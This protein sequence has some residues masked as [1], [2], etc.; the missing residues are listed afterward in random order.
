MEKKDTLSSCSESEEQQMQL[1]QDKSKESCMVSF[2]RLHSHLKRLS[3]NDL[4]GSRTENGFGRAFATLFGQDFEIFTGTMFLNM[5]QLQKQLDNNE[6]Q[7]IGSMASFK[8]LETQFQMFINS[9]IYLNDEYIV[10]TRN[11]FLQYTQ[12]DIPEFRETLVQFM[13]YVKKSIDERALHKMEYDSRLS[14][15]AIGQETQEQDT[16]S[17]SG[18]DAHVDDAD[19]RPIDN[20]EPMAE[21]QT[22]ADDNVSATRQQHTEQP[23]SNMKGEIQKKGFAIAALKN[24]L[25]KLTGNSVNTKFAKPSI[26]GKPVL[27]PHRNQSVVRQPTAF[28]SERPK[29]S[30]PRFASQVDVNNDLSKPVTTHYLPKRRESAHAKPHYMIAPSSS[31]YSSNDIVHNHYLEEAKKKTQ[32]HSRNSRNFS[33]SKH[34]VC[35]TCQKCV[36]NANHDSCVTKFLKE[37]NSRAK[38]PSNKT[39]NRNK[40]VEQI[41]VA[42]KPNRQIPTGHRFSIKR[43]STVHE[44]TTSPRS[45]LRWQPTGRILKT[46]CLRWVPTG[47][48]FTSSTTKV[49]SEPPNGSKEDITNQCESE[50]ALDVSAD[51][52]ENRA[53]RNFDLMINIMTFEHS[54]SSLGHQCQMMSDHNSS[55]LA[56]QRQ[57]MSV[58]NVTSGLVPQGQKASDYDNSDPVPPRQN[59]V[60]TAEKTDSSQQGPLLEEYYNPAH[61]HAEDNNNDQAPNAS[62]QEAEFINPFCTRVQEIG[63]PSSRNIDNT[64]VHS[65]QPQSHDYRWTRDPSLVQVNGNLTMPVQTRQKFATNPEMCM[66]AFTMDMKMTFLNGPLKEEVYVAQ[67]EGFVDPDSIQ[68]KGFQARPTTKAPQGAF[69]DTDHVGCLD[70]RKITSGGIQFL[71]DKLVAVWL[72]PQSTK[73]PNAPNQK[74]RVILMY[75]TMTDGEILLCASIKQALGRSNGG[76]VSQSTKVDVYP[77]IH[78]HS[79]KTNYHESSR[80]K[81]K[82]FR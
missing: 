21:V 42:T 29:I 1:I 9:Q 69:L 7:E 26:L 81:D 57:E 35:S 10:M 14:L 4:K 28:K 43:T 23:E 36:F 75:F 47:K 8:V 82:D 63:E 17:R 15:K 58:E 70:T 13:E 5:D 53:S 68:E 78:A 39:T 22:T 66:F 31:R 80:F 52:S 18:N 55:D 38:V 54:S 33:D 46:V 74:F 59:V 24:E 73:T 3:N 25:R 27:Q 50:Q 65:F 76:D 56:P 20:E 41:R 2:Q 11:Y 32:E 67:P 64:D 6:F 16:S 48:I 34:F 12:L 60:P 44:K 79:T 72:Q 30:K 49:D 37:V 45:C 19:I 62:F 61:G 51:I 77:H 40:P 71:G